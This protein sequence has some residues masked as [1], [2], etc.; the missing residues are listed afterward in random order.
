VTW[1]SPKEDEY[2]RSKAKFLDDLVSLL[3]GRAAEEIF[4][5]KENVTTGA[6]NDFERATQIASD[7]IMKYGMDEELGPIMYLDEDR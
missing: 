4:L 6:A 7:M 1:Y 3:G 5:G 2:L